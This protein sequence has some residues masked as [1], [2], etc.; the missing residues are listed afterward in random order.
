MHVALIAL[1]SVCVLTPAFAPALSQE[2]PGGPKSEKAQKS[3]KE[4]EQ[5]LHHSDYPSALDR[6]K[7]AHKQDAGRCRDCQ[8]QMI[9]YGA[10]LGDWKTARTRGRRRKG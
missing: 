1:F 4:A 5:Y 7:K 10:E 3:Y 8:K 2:K 9:K 6:F